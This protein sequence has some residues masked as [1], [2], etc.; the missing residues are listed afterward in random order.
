MN[1]QGNNHQ[2]PCT[3]GQWQRQ[4]L[5]LS[6]SFWNTQ[7]DRLPHQGITRKHSPK[8]Q[9]TQ[10]MTETSAHPQY[11]QLK[12]LVWLTSLPGYHKETITKDSA[13][14]D[15]DRDSSS[16]SVFATETPGL[17]DLL[18]WVSQGNNYQRLSI[19][20]QWQRQPFILSTLLLSE[21]PGLTDHLIWVSQGKHHSEYSDNDRDSRSSSG[22]LS[23]T[24]GLTDYLTW[25]TQGSDHSAYSDNCPSSVL[26]SQI[27][28]LTDHLTWVSS[29]PV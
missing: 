16:S 11:L 21:T 10:T 15:N 29:A 14:S 19:L 12:H 2:K 20:R 9:H 1:R 23:E 4:Q 13:Y 26:S 22:H 18:T 17:T 27:P 5:I 6:T 24:P 7:S 8:T 28:G 25:V 3:L